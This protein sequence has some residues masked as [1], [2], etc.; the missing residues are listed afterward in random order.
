MDEHFGV[1]L[2]ISIWKI[3]RVKEQRKRQA[4]SES[5]AN[6]RIIYIWIFVRSLC[7]ISIFDVSVA[8]ALQDAN[9]PIRKV[10]DLNQLKVNWVMD[11]FVGCCVFGHELVVSPSNTA[12]SSSQQCV[13]AAYRIYFILISL[14]KCLVRLVI[15]WL[16]G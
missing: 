13:R 8:S 5:G 14:L 1:E 4:K 10:M 11:S 12:T 3:R 9:R 7:F 16:K 2:K 6:E 15:N